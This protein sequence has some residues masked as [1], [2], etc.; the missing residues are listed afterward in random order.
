MNIDSLTHD[1]RRYLEELNPIRKL[2]SLKLTN[3]QPPKFVPGKIKPAKSMKDIADVIND[4]DENIDEYCCHLDKCF[5]RITVK[6][7]KDDDVS[8]FGIGSTD[9]SARFAA[10]TRLIQKLEK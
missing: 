7:T 9:R 5:V 6:N 1:S 8:A 10:A 3:G 4:Q 2:M